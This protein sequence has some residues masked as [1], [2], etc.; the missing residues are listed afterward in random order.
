MEK[1]A[2]LKDFVAIIPPYSHG[3]IFKVN[4]TLVGARTIDDAIGLFRKE[5][6]TEAVESVILQSKDGALLQNEIP[7]V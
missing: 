4:H 1:E 5:Y 3:Y 2:I 7:V 6:P